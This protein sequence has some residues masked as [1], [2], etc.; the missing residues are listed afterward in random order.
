MGPRG[1]AYGYVLGAGFIYSLALAR[2]AEVAHGSLKLREETS[3][4]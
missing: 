4:N 2:R 1:Q 3:G